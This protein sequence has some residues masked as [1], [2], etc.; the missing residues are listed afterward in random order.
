MSGRKRKVERGKIKMLFVIFA[1]R[2]DNVARVQ[3]VSRKVG[4]EN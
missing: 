1:V 2:I 3:S 4:V